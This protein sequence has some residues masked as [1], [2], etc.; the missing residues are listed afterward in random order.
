MTTKKEQDA[1]NNVFGKATRVSASK[2]K[3]G[4]EEVEFN[5]PFDTLVNVAVVE[6]ALEGVKENLTKQFKEVAFEVFASKIKEELKQPESFK[7]VC[8]ETSASFQFRKRGHGFSEEIANLLASKEIPFTTEEK[9]EEQYVINPIIL[10]DQALL[11]KLA[12]AIQSLKG[13]EDIEVVQVVEAPKKYQFTDATLAGVVCK[14]TEDEQKQ[15]LDEVSTLALADC[16]LAGENHKNQ[17]TVDT[18]LQNLISKGILQYN[19]EA[20][21]SK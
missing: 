10:K 13:F 9:G 20:K 17:T 7:A 14:C 2:K 1:I 4:K 6:K 19:D 3:K 21:K 11:A 15:I 16:R 18:A 12:V 8:N 5:A